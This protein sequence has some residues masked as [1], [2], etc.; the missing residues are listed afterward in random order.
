MKYPNGL[1][2]TEETNITQE[3]ITDRDNVQNQQQ[4][5]QLLQKWQAIAPEL[6]NLTL[7]H[8]VYQKIKQNKNLQE[9][10]IN[11]TTGLAKY[12]QVLAPKTLL[13]IFQTA[14]HYGVNEGIVVMQLMRIK[15]DGT[16]TE[17]GAWW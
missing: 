7:T 15:T 5:D 4:L 13:K 8:T 12:L 3:Y 9:R 2:I 10:I 1:Q 14:R 17:E 6:Q 16:I 11:K